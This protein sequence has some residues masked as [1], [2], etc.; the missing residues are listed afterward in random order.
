MNDAPYTWTASDPA[1]ITMVFPRRRL[2][3]EVEE[4]EWMRTD[5]VSR[6]EGDA[7]LVD[8][9]VNL[10]SFTGGG[11]DV[12]GPSW[13][14]TGNYWMVETTDNLKQALEN[15]NDKIGDRTYTEDNYLTD[16]ETIPASLDALD[17]AI[18]DNADAISSTSGDKYLEALSSNLSAGVEHPL[19][20]SVVYTPV[21]IGGQEGQNMDVYHNG[22][23]LAA[24]T[25]AAGVNADRDYAETSASGITFHMDLYQ[26]DNIT[27]VIRS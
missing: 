15:I 7:E 11:D 17:Q 6:W 27:Y 2:L 24:S 5:F 9:M 19:P 4:W 3:S 18:K 21:A 13:S 26:D 23:L 16:G 1:N 8:D 12:V 25:G 20:N 14:N 10:W 22:Q